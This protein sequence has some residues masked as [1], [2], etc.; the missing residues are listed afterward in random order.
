M[1]GATAVH[2]E[3]DRIVPAARFRIDGSQRLY[4]FFAEFQAELLRVLHL[5]QQVLSENAAHHYY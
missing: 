3:E 4:L 2:V 5:L 1:A